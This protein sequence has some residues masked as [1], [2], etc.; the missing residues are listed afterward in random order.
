MKFVF[1]CCVHTLLGSNVKC[2]SYSR[3]Q[4]KMWKTPEWTPQSSTT[5]LSD[6]QPS[7]HTEHV[8]CTWIALLPRL[9]GS[10]FHIWKM[11]VTQMLLWTVDQ[12]LCLLH[13]K[14]DEVPKD[15][16]FPLF[17]DRKPMRHSKEALS[18]DVSTGGKRKM[19]SVDNKNICK[20]RSFLLPWTQAP[21]HIK[22]G[23]KPNY[24]WTHLK[25]ASL[26]FPDVWG[27]KLQ[28]VL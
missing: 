21:I 23:L 14:W 12:S 10:S 15:S 25:T 26:I 11:V 28:S 16:L 17:S 8:P 24:V 5:I 27:Q 6:R 2:V 4:T 3:V 7:N 13:I 18:W 9:S 1:Q 19:N 20:T 22:K